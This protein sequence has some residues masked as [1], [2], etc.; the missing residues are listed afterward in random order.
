M[1]NEA[2]ARIEAVLL[3]DDD[4]CETRAVD[5]SLVRQPAFEGTLQRGIT[6]LLA[7]L[8]LWCSTLWQSLAT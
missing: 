4:A 3:G 6:G 2:A 1:Q 8:P 5:R 7:K